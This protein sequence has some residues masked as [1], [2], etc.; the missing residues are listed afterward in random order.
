[1]TIDEIKELIHVVHETGIA[2]LE[3]Q[4]GDNRV[5]IRRSSAMSQDVVVPTVLSVPVAAPQ[6]QFAQ[7][8]GLTDIT[9]H[10]TPPPPLPPAEDARDSVV[11]SPIVGTY[12]DAPSPGIA[13]F[14][15]IGDRVEPKQVLCIIESMK[16]MNEI[17]AEMAGMLIAK[18][19]E[20]GRPVEYGESLFTIRP[21]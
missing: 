11:K 16:L 3:V 4:R 18:H 7:T 1:M 8:S 15:K 6:A 20:N 10:I 17:E 5:R 19:V 13:P 14:V 21:F 12:Y 2:E 9:G